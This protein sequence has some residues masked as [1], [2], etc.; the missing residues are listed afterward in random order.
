MFPEKTRIVIEIDGS[1]DS[2]ALESAVKFNI[3][4]FPR[5]KSFTVNGKSVMEYLAR[6]KCETKSKI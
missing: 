2:I 4:Q 6:L 1:I 5:M 3:L